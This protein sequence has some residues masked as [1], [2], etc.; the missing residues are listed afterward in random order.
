MTG[1]Q[2]L[3]ELEDEIKWTHNDGKELTKYDAIR[4]EVIRKHLYALDVLIMNGIFDNVIIVTLN[5]GNPFNLDDD[6]FKALEQL[7]EVIDNEDVPET[8]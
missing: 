4:V 2:A 1:I 3:A 7:K 6:E 5:R 8:D